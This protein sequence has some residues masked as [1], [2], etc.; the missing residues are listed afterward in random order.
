MCLY[1]GPYAWCHIRKYHTWQLLKIPQRQD[2]GWVEREK[3]EKDTLSKGPRADF[4]FFKWVPKV[5]I[6]QLSGFKWLCKTVRQE[7]QEQRREGGWLNCQAVG[8]APCTLVGL[9]ELQRDQRVKPERT[10]A[11]KKVGGKWRAPQ[12]GHH[13]HEL[14]FFQ[15]PRLSP[16]PRSL[17]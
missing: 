15:V 12:G 1:L 17:Q 5:W 4:F 13:L 10:E 6:G 3:L 11:F 7:S 16:R 8:L 9:T 14:D 2:G